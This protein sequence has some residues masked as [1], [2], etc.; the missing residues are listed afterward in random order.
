MLVAGQLKFIVVVSLEHR[1]SVTFITTSPVL[2]AFHSLIWWAN[3][4]LGTVLPRLFGNVATVERRDVARHQV[5]RI[6]RHEIHVRTN[7]LTSSVRS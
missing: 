6:A 2:G 5:V 7:D 1:T 4:S 3:Y